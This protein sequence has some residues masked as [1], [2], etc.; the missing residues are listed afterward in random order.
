GRRGLDLPG[1]AARSA[2]L[3]GPGRGGPAQASDS[4]SGACVLLPARDLGDDRG[5]CQVRPVRPAPAVG[6]DRGHAVNRS[7][8][9][10]GASLGLA[11]ASPLLAAAALAIKL[12]DGGPVFYRQ[13]RVGRDGREFELVKLRTMVVGAEDQ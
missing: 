2:G 13:R 3:A 7:L 11:L 5:A 8:D 1:G 6:A 9:V 12:D 4:G 10:A